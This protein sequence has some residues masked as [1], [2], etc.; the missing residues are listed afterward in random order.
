MDDNRIKGTI[1]TE[2]GYL[3]SMLYLYALRRTAQPCTPDCPLSRPARAPYNV[4]LIATH[5]CP[6]CARSDMDTN[7]IEGTIPTEMGL[8]TSMTILY[9]P[10]AAAAQQLSASGA[11]VTSRAHSTPRACAPPAHEQGARDQLAA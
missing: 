9:A 7:S 3:T 10:P 4:G 6:T 8:L 11:V 1:P 5:A 2:V